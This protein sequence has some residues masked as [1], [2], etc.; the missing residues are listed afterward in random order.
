MSNIKD[1]VNTIISQHRT[2]DPFK[3]CELMNI[4]VYD[5]ELPESVNGMYTRMC[6]KDIVILNN[7]LE[8]YKRLSV[9]AHELGHVILHEGLNCLDIERNTNFFASKF[10]YEADLFAA[11]LLINDETVEE[12]TLAE[13]ITVTQIAQETGIP[14]HLVQLRFQNCLQTT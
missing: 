5:L 10:E 1:K 11:Y 12:L 6:N 2:S 7:A 3:L 13:P 4:P 14:E 8:D 9:C